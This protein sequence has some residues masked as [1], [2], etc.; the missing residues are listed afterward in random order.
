[1]VSERV[2]NLEFL[3]GCSTCGCHCGKRVEL[4]NCQAK[5]FNIF[6]MHVF[7][8]TPVHQEV[9]GVRYTAPCVHAMSGV[10]PYKFVGAG[11]DCAR[12]KMQNSARSV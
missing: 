2:L 7:V 11:L 10:I 1:M 4:C 8:Y 5:C 6:V 3:S 12:K 9:L